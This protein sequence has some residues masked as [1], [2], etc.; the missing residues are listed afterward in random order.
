MK[1]TGQI[2]FASTFN[3]ESDLKLTFNYSII[4]YEVRFIITL[5]STQ[6]HYFGIVSL[7]VFDFCCVFGRGSSFFFFNVWYFSEVLSSVLI[8]TRFKQKP[9]NFNVRIPLFIG[10]FNPVSIKVFIIEIIVIRRI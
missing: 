10:N 8:N 1:T 4:I 9:L 6:N 3:R 7:Y 5:V 2:R